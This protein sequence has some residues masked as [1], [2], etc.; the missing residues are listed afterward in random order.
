M[1]S[2]DD[3]DWRRQ[4]SYPARERFAMCR[5]LSSTVRT[6][7]EPVRRPACEGNSYICLVCA[8]RRL[9]TSPVASVGGQ[10]R[11]TFPT[12]RGQRAA[13][14]NQWRLAVMQASLALLWQSVVCVQQ[15]KPFKNA[16]SLLVA[17]ARPLP[18][19][20]TSSPSRRCLMPAGRVSCRRHPA[21]FVN[22][23]LRMRL[24][25]WTSSRT[26][27]RAGL[28]RPK[29]AAA[30]R[31][32]SPSP[33]SREIRRRFVGSRQHGRRRTSSPASPIRLRLYPRLVSFGRAKTPV[34]LRQRR[35]I[36]CRCLVVSHQT[37][38][39]VPRLSLRRS[40]FT[41]L[42][43]ARP[44]GGQAPA[45]CPIAALPA[46]TA[47]LARRRL[48]PRSTGWRRRKTGVASSPR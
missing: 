8:P 31:I 6:S 17:A 29:H 22:C 40:P 47:F 37:R 10:K 24:S 14:T 18:R 43:R 33:V 28:A 4:H 16:V 12:C 26:G 27:R 36:S 2:V 20:L 21:S 23:G 48:G 44:L 15:Q 13:V 7:T 3:D 41:H 42:S 35:I 5:A 30:A 45:S 39:M 9:D 46:A 25:A 1:P 38:T 11:G 32:T 19:L 34:S